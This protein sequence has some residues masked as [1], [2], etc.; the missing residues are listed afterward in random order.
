MVDRLE[1]EEPTTVD[2]PVD[3]DDRR[4]EDLDNCNDDRPAGLG[5]GEREAEL[6]RV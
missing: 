5:D 2:P 4:E 3:C 1:V 6:E